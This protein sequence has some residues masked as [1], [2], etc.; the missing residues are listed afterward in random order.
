MCHRGRVGI[1]AMCLCVVCLGVLRAETYISLSPLDTTALPPVKPTK[2]EMHF[3]QNMLESK[4]F[5]R[6][7]Q[8]RLEREHYS[9]PAYFFH[10][11]TDDVVPFLNSEH[12]TRS[13]SAPDTT[14]GAVSTPPHI[15]CDF[16]DYGSHMAACILFLQRTYNALP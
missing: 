3:L 13:L 6:V 5:W 2:C 16:A 4:A 7:L 12:L 8:R 10:S 11:T 14:S 15:T 9:C 1:I